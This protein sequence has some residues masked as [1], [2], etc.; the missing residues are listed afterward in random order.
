MS[1]FGPGGMSLDPLD[2]LNFLVDSGLMGFLGILNRASW[3]S[4]SLKLTRF[5]WG[6][7]DAR[8]LLRG[9]SFG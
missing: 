4:S 6:R 2:F 7:V 9:L 3:A 5:V 8:Q 1:G